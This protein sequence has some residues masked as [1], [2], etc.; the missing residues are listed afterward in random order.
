[1]IEA[2]L[3]YGRPVV[4]VGPPGVGPIRFDPAPAFAMHP[5]GQQMLISGSL[6]D[7][8]MQHVLAAIDPAGEGTT[9][10]VAT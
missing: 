5:E 7:P 6:D 8:Q 3:P 9:L 10:R 1:V 4:L 2:R